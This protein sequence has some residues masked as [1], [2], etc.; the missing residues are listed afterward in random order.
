MITLQSIVKFLTDLGIETSEDVVGNILPSTLNEIRAYT[1][2]FFLTTVSMK[3]VSFVVSENTITFEG[4]CPFT[5]GQFIEF[6]NSEFNTSIMSIKEIDDGVITVN[7]TLFDE[8]IED[9]LIQLSFRGVSLVSVANMVGFDIT[10]GTTRD[11]KKQTLSGGY[12]VEYFGVS[13]NG[14]PRMYPDTLYGGI[15]GLRKLNSD[16]DEYIRYGYRKIIR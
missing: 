2:Q 5:K 13:E 4:E 16:Y 7:Q 8:E 6:L 15:K 12:S 1:N 3:D 11:I 10:K 9:T 14:I